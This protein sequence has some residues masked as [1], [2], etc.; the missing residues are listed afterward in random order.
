MGL[1]F[2]FVTDG[3]FAQ[4]PSWQ[5]ISQLCLFSKRDR[6]NQIFRYSFIKNRKRE[7]K[8]VMCTFRHDR[9][10]SLS[11]FRCPEKTC[12]LPL[13]SGQALRRHL[14]SIRKFKPST[15]PQPNMARDK[16]MP[17]HLTVI[18]LRSSS[19][20]GILSAYK[21]LGLQ[22]YLLLSLCQNTQPVIH[23]PGVLWKPFCI[24]TEVFYQR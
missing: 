17:L 2:K 15:L 3:K 7:K 9:I 11:K 13:S 20:R 24:Q 10:G 22:M 14:V 21:H 16:Q 12:L 4:N 5:K 23:F 19:S 18:L 6:V 1:G 8:T